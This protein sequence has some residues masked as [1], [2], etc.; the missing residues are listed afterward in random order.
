[1]FIAL[2]FKILCSPL[3]G[4]M[5]CQ[6]NSIPLGDFQDHLMMVTL[7]PQTYML[8]IYPLM[9]FSALHMSCQAYMLCL[10]ILTGV[11]ML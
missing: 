1:M 9:L 6:M 3:A 4:L 5:N 2:M 7:K 10:V 8:P 11:Y